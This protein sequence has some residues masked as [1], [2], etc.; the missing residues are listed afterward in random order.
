M[1]VHRKY[2]SKVQST[3]CKFF[4]IYLLVFLYIAL[5]VSGGSSA[6]HQKHKT[7][8]TASGIV[9]PILLP[10]AIVDE[11]ELMSSISSMIAA[12]S[13]IGLTIPDAV[14]TVFC[15]WWWAEEP[16]ETCRAIYRNKQIEKTLHLVGCTSTLEISRENFQ[17][18]VEEFTTSWTLHNVSF[19]KMLTRDTT[20]ARNVWFWSVN[21]NPLN[22]E[23]NPICYLLA[24]L[25]AHHFLH[26]SRIR[27][28]SLT[29][30]LLMSYI[31]I[32]STHSW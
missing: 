13:S 30:R 31:Y 5:H 12:G 18:Y 15:S 22:P 6:H 14:C 27:V 16:P 20:S 4:S 19:I 23:L 9:K 11:M 10:A 8:H 3:K 25:G 7:V 32:W 21:V 26:V 24:L 2:I 17:S 1:S 28:K 29:F